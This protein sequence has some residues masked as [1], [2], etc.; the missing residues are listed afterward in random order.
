MRKSNKMKTAALGLSAALLATMY[1]VQLQAMVNPGNTQIKK[2]VSGKMARKQEKRKYREGEVIVV[3]KSGVTGASVADLAVEGATAASADIQLK[4]VFAFGGEQCDTGA[5]AATGTA[6]SAEADFVIGFYTS[7]TKTT[8]QM[9]RELEKNP[10][11]AYAEPNYLAYISGAT[12]DT[13]ADEQWAIQNV[14]QNGGTAGI[15]TGVESVW[16]GVDG[17]VPATKGSNRVVALL[18]T[19]VDLGH[20]DLA[21]H[22]WNNPYQGILPGEHGYDFSNEDEDP[23]DDNGHGTHCAGII[24]ADADNKLGVSGIC[25]GVTIMPLKVFDGSGEGDLYGVLQAFDYVY[26]AKRLGVDIVATS[27]SWGFGEYPRS[28]Q[29]AIKKIGK[30]G[31]LSIFAAGNDGEDMD[32]KDAENIG[33]TSPYVIHVASLNENGVLNDFSN[34]GKTQVDLAAPGSGILSTVN[35]GVFNPRL[36]QKEETESSQSMDQ[37]ADQSADQAQENVISLYRNYDQKEAPDYTMDA[38]GIFRADEKVDG[39]PSNIAVFE[40]T[41]EHNKEAQVRVSRCENA[42]YGKTGAAL[43]VEISGMQKEDVAVITIP[44]QKPA[45]QK[46]ESDISFMLKSTLDQTYDPGNPGIVGVEDV[47]DGE[48]EKCLAETKTSISITDLLEGKLD[49]VDNIG[50][51]SGAGWVHHTM[52]TKKNTKH[53]A[54][55][56]NLVFKL[57]NSQEDGTCT[58]YLD[59]LGVTKGVDIN[60]MEHYPKYDYYSGTSMATPYVTGAVALL[61][62]AYPKA[63]AAELMEQICGSVTQM[64]T[65]KEK[66]ITGGRLDLSKIAT[67]RPVLTQE[68]LDTKG[69]L[70]ISG[71]G[72]VKGQTTIELNGKKVTPTSVKEKEVVVEAKGYQNCYVDLTVTTPY[73]TSQ[74]QVYLKAGKSYTT[75]GK[76]CAW[77]L[78]LEETSDAVDTLQ[79]IF[80]KT[81]APATDGEQL[82]IY[83]PQTYAI[84]CLT[85]K[86][87]TKTKRIIDFSQTNTLQTEAGAKKTDTVTVN[88]NL[89]YK[90]K[91]LY[92]IANVKAANSVYHTLQLCSVTTNKERAKVEVEAALP[93]AYQYISDPTLANY[94]GTIYL[95]GGYDHHKKE[96]SKVT[97]A[98]QTVNGKKTWKKAKALPQGRLGGQAVQVGGKLYYALGASKKGDICPKTLVFDGKKWRTLGQTL[99]ETY[100]KGTVSYG[101]QNYD[102]YKGTISPYGDQLCFSGMAVKGLGDTFMQDCRTG[103]Y[104]KASV[105]AISDPKNQDFI[106]VIVGKQLMGILADYGVLRN[107]YTTM[108]DNRYHITVQSAPQHARIIC[109]PKAFLAGDRVTVK[110]V[111]DAGYALDKLV[112]NGKV[113]KKGVYQGYPTKDLVVK[114]SLKKDVRIPEDTGIRSKK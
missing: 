90:D 42:G 78:D 65:L 113:V 84:E 11:I 68:Q 70:H 88:S 75:V 12:Q 32:A 35:M 3:Y 83:N 63:D 45:E 74:K 20:E 21:D 81:P 9:I 39:Y 98:L 31:I 28:L 16:N 17:V 100:K 51:E 49:L 67:P 4:D 93:K 29:K 54:V 66:T 60:E 94:K 22:I 64:D 108:R 38:N 56:G 104:K 26:Q 44:Y 71:Y 105:N 55:S 101:S 48:V 52:S 30:Q 10:K 77:E 23:S 72:F 41:Y 109:S 34:Y 46:K 110:V 95:L 96:F 36:M 2:S 24:S 14:G 33:W 61:A 50:S 8:Q 79:G 102:T 25:P 97:Y 106:G 37:S 7:R 107:S 86:K 62:Q 15:D 1:P 89:I 73:G 82:Y 85:Q 6:E 13:Y 57:Y 5:E 53:K 91:H 80:Q 40:D 103:A 69:S 43:K 76:K 58:L 112:I 27:N 18:D 111:P 92:Y 59:D 19:G 87:D 114:A 99:P 47:S